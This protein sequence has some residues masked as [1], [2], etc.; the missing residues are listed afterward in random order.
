MLESKVL[1]RGCSSMVERQLPKL[2]TRVRFPSPACLFNIKDL[3]PPA[4]RNDPNFYQNFYPLTPAGSE[5]E[6]LRTRTRRD[7]SALS[8]QFGPRVVKQRLDR[9]TYLSRLTKAGVDQQSASSESLS[10]G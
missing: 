10:P 5:R 6:P 3:R 8:T 1:V 9:V 2:D 7:V 4:R